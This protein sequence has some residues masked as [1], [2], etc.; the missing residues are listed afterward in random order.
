MIS[1]FFHKVL[2]FYQNLV[3]LLPAFYRISLFY[4]IRR[5]QNFVKF[6]CYNCDIVLYFIYACFLS[7]FSAK[8]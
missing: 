3:L 5:Y 2:Y 1:V 4:K 8:I 7:Y 6:L